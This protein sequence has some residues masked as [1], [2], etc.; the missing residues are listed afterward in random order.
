M[1]EGWEASGSGSQR[2]TGQGSPTSS[3]LPSL[4]GC[5][6]PPTSPI[7]LS[8]VC[9]S[10]DGASCC[11]VP[12]AVSPGQ[13]Y[14]C[15]HIVS[16]L[17][18]NHAPPVRQAW[19]EY[20]AMDRQR[21]SSRVGGR[22]GVGLQATMPHLSVRQARAEWAVQNDLIRS[23]AAL[24]DT[25]FATQTS[26]RASAQSSQSEASEPWSQARRAQQNEAD[27][28]PGARR[29]RIVPRSIGCLITRG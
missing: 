3:A 23:H 12:P 15:Q 13:L 4:C 1:W 27:S 20:T 19:R 7:P 18:G 16:G 5:C 21:V 25:Q 17:V 26:Q 10:L 29:A 8:R 2:A 9:Y 11:V 28:S 24:N 22:E 6:P 14:I